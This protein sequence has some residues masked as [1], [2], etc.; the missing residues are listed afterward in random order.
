VEKGEIAGILNGTATEALLALSVHFGAGEGRDVATHLAAHHPSDRIR[1]R[2][3]HALA[4]AEPDAGARMR[5]Y[6]RGATEPNR[7]V[8]AE[9]M[10][11]LAAAERTG[12]W[13]KGL[14]AENGP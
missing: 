7:F 1:M 3:W 14:V 12:I 11:A 4:S 6:E 2:A 8:S 10:R 13:L 9:C 5:C